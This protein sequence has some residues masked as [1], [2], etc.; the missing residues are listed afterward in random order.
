MSCDSQPREE[1]NLEPGHSL[2]TSLDASIDSVL[3][4]DPLCLGTDSSLFDSDFGDIFGTAEA[5][6]HD[7][8]ETAAKL[9]ALVAPE[10]ASAGLPFGLRL[11][12]SESFCNLINRHLAETRSAVSANQ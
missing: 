9:E 11:K 2:D 5:P 3:D 12:K 4:S 6:Q 10:K 1:L 7:V 8:L